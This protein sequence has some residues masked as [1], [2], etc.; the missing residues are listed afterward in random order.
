MLLILD[1]M[2]DVIL[3]ALV[4]AALDAVLHTI[5]QVRRVILDTIFYAML[6]DVL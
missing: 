6:H 5:V 4:D 2:L 1:A 3:S